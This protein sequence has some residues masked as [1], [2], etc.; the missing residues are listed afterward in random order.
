MKTHTSSIASRAPLS[1]FGAASW[2]EVLINL[3]RRGVAHIKHRR[4]VRQ[5]LAK[6]LE[7]DDH[8]LADIGISRAELLHSIGYGRLPEHRRRPLDRQ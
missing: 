7:F 6:L 2:R 4:Q 8:L 1:G 3:V 5:D